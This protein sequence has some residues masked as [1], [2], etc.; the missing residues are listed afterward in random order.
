MNIVAAIILG[1]FVF[2]TSVVVIA[3]FIWAAVKD[4]QEDKPCRRVSASAAGRGSGVSLTCGESFRSSSRPRSSVDCPRRRYS[5][6]VRGLADWRDVP[7][8]RTTHVSIAF[9]T[10]ASAGTCQ[11]L[12]RNV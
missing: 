3:L 1:V 8:G 11:G 4:G 10:R 5:V 6:A 9:P 7:S 2:L 12:R